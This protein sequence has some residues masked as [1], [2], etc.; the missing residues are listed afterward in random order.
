LLR[1]NSK[2]FSVNPG[3][4]DLL[5]SPRQGREHGNPPFPQNPSAAV[6]ESLENQEPRE[7]YKSNSQWD[8]EDIYLSTLTKEDVSEHD[9]PDVER[10]PQQTQ[11]RVTGDQIADSGM[12]MQRSQGEYATKAVQ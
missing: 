8:A 11:V 1:K 6:E 10:I 3:P 7:Q 2:E 9:D 4:S 12:N 5:E